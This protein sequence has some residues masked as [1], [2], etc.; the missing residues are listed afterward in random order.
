MTEPIS[1]FHALVRNRNTYVGSVLGALEYSTNWFVFPNRSTTPLFQ[2]RHD[3]CLQCLEARSDICAKMSTQGTAVALQQDLEIS[4]GLSR[5]DHAERVL[6]SRHG[7]ID[8]VIAGDL[9][10]HPRVWPTF[11]SLSSRV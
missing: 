5:F 2:R 7:Q 6:L 11:V 3:G 4:A 9:E 8:G 1:T 10:E